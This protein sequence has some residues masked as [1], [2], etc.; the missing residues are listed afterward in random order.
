LGF[1][2]IHGNDSEGVAPCIQAGAEAITQAGLSLVV[3]VSGVIPAD[4]IVV[5]GEFTFVE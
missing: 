4:A 2:F 5:D 1:V 3:W